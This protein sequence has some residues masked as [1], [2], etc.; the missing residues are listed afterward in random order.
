MFAAAAQ[1]LSVDD[2]HKLKLVWTHEPA[3]QGAPD[4][5]A[6]SRSPAYPSLWE[7]PAPSAPQPLGFPYQS[8]SHAALPGA[9]L[10]ISLDPQA[11]ALSSAHGGRVLVVEQRLSAQKS[12]HHGHNEGGAASHSVSCVHLSQLESR[13]IS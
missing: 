11:V 3:G 4:S 13:G 6:S 12:R 1:L 8:G 9:E 7:R 5:G 2:R 10:A